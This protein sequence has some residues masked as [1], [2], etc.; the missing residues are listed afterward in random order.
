MGFNG[1]GEQ[2]IKQKRQAS[3]QGSGIEEVANFYS[4]L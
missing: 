2:G 1:Y 3:M 4:T